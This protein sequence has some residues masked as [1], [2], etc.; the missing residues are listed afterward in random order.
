[1]SERVKPIVSRRT[2]GR[3]E[4]EISAL[5]FILKVTQGQLNREHKRLIVLC[6][7]NEML[8]GASHRKIIKEYGG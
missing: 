1:M 7:E 2:I 3:M 5:R 8:G 4:G 6:R